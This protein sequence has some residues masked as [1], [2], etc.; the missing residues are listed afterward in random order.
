MTGVLPIAKYSSGSSINMFREY[1]ILNDKKYYKYFGFTIKETENLCKKQNEVTFDEL[2]NWYNGYKTYSGIDIFNPRSVVYALSDGVCQNYWTNTGPM[3]EI[4]Y[5]V[6]NNIDSIKNDIIQMT[7][8][9]PLEIKLKGY[10]AEQIVLNNLNQILS[11]MT[12]YGF[13]SYYD[14]KLVIPNK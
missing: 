8:G 13:L 14:K 6:N 9:I 11:A 7:T 4:L 10:S 5:Y 3:D 12:I 2:K 1:N